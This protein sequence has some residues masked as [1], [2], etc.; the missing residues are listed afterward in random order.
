MVAAELA[1]AKKGRAMDLEVAMAAM[2]PGRDMV[3]GTIRE[4][5][6]AVALGTDKAAT[7]QADTVRGAGK[8]GS[9]STKWKT[10]KSFAIFRRTESPAVEI[11]CTWKV[12]RIW[13]KGRAQESPAARRERELVLVL[14]Q[15]HGTSLATEAEKVRLSRRTRLD[16]GLTRTMRTN[17]RAAGEKVESPTERVQFLVWRWVARW[18]RKTVEAVVERQRVG[19][20]AA[21]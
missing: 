3:P 20:E 11:P 18:D 13:R 7:H 4:T 2:D 8:R 14:A 9:F 12:L 5:K 16:F 1:P 17:R 19:A 6:A 15:A 10:P 21:E